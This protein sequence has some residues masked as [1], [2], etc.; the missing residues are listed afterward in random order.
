MSLTSLLNLIVSERPGQSQSQRSTCAIKHIDLKVACVNAFNIP[1]VNEG[2]I[3]IY[4]K[5]SESSYAYKFV[6]IGTCT[7]R[8]YPSSTNRAECM[9]PF[10]LSELVT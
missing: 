3:S 6:E 1:Q 9:V 7:D 4:N 10:L 8:S 5:M 2:G